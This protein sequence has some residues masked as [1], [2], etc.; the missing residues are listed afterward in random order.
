[1]VLNRVEKDKGNSTPSGDTARP[2]LPAGVGIG[3][4]IGIGIGM[5]LGIGIAGGVTS[6]DF[7]LHFL[8]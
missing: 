8:W 1:M 4:W 5:R 3:I 7:T 6:Y 2:A